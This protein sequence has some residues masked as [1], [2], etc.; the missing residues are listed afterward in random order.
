M[1][2]KY[3]LRTLGLLCLLTLLTSLSV[4]TAQDMMVIEL[5]T[6]IDEGAAEQD[7]FVMGED[8]MAYRV[9]LA[10][11]LSM[12]TEPIYGLA[13]AE[14]F[15]FDPFQLYD[16]PVGPYEIGEPLNHTMKEWLAARGGGT[17]SMDGDI[18]MVDFMFYDLVPDGVYTLRC[19]TLTPPPDFNVLNE[20]CGAEDGTE[21]IFT[22]DSHGELAMQMS[23]PADAST[24]RNRCSGTGDCVARG[25]RNLWRRPRTIRYKN[26]HSSAHSGHS[27]RVMCPVR[28]S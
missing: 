22:A 12:L 18:A 28:K 5:D 13:N 1:Q 19:S 21:N 20:P 26:L 9:T 14:D 7:V 4:V 10:S 3:A 16:N 27:N 25:R 2:H 24:H 17:Y 8:G 11:P 23:F 6:F 15:V